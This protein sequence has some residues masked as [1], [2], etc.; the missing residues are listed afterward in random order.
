[1]TIKDGN[2]RNQATP[3]KIGLVYESCAFAHDLPVDDD[4]LMIGNRLFPGDDTP[5]TFINCNLVNCEPPPGSTLITTNT[6]IVEN[7]K[8]VG[9][10]DVTID[11]E[12]ISTPII[13][14]WIYGKCLADGSYFYHPQIIKVSKE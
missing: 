13:E 4:G 12:T 9:S 7:G 3:S 6:T 11:G 2:F 5:R 8:V 10:D 14:N 1:M